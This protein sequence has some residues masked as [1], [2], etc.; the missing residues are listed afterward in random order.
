MES[1]FIFELTA[2]LGFLLAAF[3]VVGVTLYTGKK[4]KYG[5]VYGLIGLVTL[6]P[7]VLFFAGNPETWKLILVLLV[8]LV[9]VAVAALVAIMVYLQFV[10]K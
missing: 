2:L 8:A 4:L 5:V 1:M 10:L 9:G 7:F 3:G 6:L